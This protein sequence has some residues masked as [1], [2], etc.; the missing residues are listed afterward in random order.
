[1]VAAVVCDGTVLAQCTQKVLVC[2]VANARQGSFPMFHHAAVNTW[3]TK[4]NLITVMHNVF[5]EQPHVCVCAEEPQTVFS[6]CASEGQSA[7]A[8]HVCTLSGLSRHESC[9]S[10]PERS[11]RHVTES[12]CNEAMSE[13]AACVLHAFGACS[14][15]AW[16]LMLVCRKAVMTVDIPTLCCGLVDE[17][18]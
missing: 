15:R 3:H 16:H 4:H 8:P 1:M 18:S 11:E 14:G 17:Q 9:S 5:A 2:W 6:R 7:A 10:C 12:C 13:P